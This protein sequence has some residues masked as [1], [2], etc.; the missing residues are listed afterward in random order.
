ML[1]CREVVRISAGNGLDD[2][3]ASTGGTVRR[4]E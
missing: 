1:D 4:N 3:P 2:W